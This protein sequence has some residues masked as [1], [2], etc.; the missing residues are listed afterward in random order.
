[1]NSPPT[2]GIARHDQRRG[3]RDLINA[4]KLI[5]T[6]GLRGLDATLATVAG[7]ALMTAHAR[8]TEPQTADSG[9]RWP[10]QATVVRTAAAPSASS[11]PC[12]VAA[13]CCGLVSPLGCCGYSCNRRRIACR[14]SAGSKSRRL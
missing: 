14:L 10:G 4:A 9:E 8:A 5:T 1:M 11:E 2:Q 13:L 12:T 7:H 6:R 3:R